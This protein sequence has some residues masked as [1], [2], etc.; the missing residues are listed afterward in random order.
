MPTI[1]NARILGVAGALFGAAL[2][3]WCVGLLARQGLHAIVL[4]AALPGLFAGASSKERSIGWAV[5][6]GAIG[7]V[8][9]LL[10][11]WRYRP[12]IADSSLGYF[13]RHLNDLQLIVLIVI[14]IGA[15]LGAILSVSFGRSR[16]SAPAKPNA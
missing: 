14:G 13:F 4:P 2:G 10:T 15:S 9:A 12:F 3:Y 8:A 6:Y 1:T 16:R 7:I 5:L 11:E